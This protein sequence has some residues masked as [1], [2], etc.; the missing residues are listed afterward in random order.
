MG[1]AKRF[2]ACVTIVAQEEGMCAL[3]YL[4]YDEV[5]AL[6]L[7][8]DRHGHLGVG[9]YEAVDADAGGADFLKSDALACAIGTDIAMAEETPRDEHVHTCNEL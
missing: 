5:D 9:E 6:L 3:P 7:Y 8:A 4:R 1:R 2:N